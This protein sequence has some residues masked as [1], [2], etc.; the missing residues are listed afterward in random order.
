MT[1]RAILQCASCESKT[2]VRTQVGHRDKQEH[3]FQ[4]PKC[5]IEIS[6][7]LDLDQ[8]N[9]SWS[10]REPYNAKW[11]Q[12]EECAVTVRT[13]SDELMIPTDL[14]DPWSPFILTFWNFKDP[15]VYRHD[16]TLRNMFIKRGW[17]RC[18]RL[19]VHFEKKN[20]DL[21]D[22]EAGP[23]DTPGPLTTLSRLEA[24]NAHMEDAFDCFTRNTEGTYR[25]VAQRIAFG[26]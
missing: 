8:K 20:F 12:S 26:R 11:V 4:C 15:D 3:A 25:R 18:E 19:M 5:G 16:E 23:P 7:V 17:A 6:Y 14:Q 2:V 1:I 13:F 24:L 10:F 22:K 9:A 21:F